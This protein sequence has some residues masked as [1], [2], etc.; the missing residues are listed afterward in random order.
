MTASPREGVEQKRGKEGVSRGNGVD[1]AGCEGS[2]EGERSGAED[3]EGLE[4]AASEGGEC[5][6]S[7]SARVAGNGDAGRPWCVPEKEESPG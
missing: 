5:R 2:R 1:D 4:R 7:V 6:G 3:G